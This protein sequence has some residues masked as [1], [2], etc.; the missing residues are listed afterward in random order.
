MTADRWD[1]AEATACTT[2]LQQLAYA[3]RLIGGDPD[4]VLHGGG[5]TSVKTTETDLTGAPIEVL[6][7][8]GSGHHLADIQPTGF[9]PLRLARL[10][11]LL[12]VED[13]PDERMMNE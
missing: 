13:L 7:V 5:N 4:L 12:T 2:A 1:P 3:S 8:K 10:R 6:H 11:E 9:A